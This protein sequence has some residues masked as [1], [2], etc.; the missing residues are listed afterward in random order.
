MLLGGIGINLGTF[1]LF[2]GVFAGG[3]GAG[4]LQR[5]YGLDGP[6]MD[7][8]VGFVGMG[9]VSVLVAVGAFATW[10]FA[11]GL[12]SLYWSTFAGLVRFFFLWPVFTIVAGVGGPSATC[13]VKSSTPDRA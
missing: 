11:S 9:V 7:A 12:V 8:R 6:P 13:S 10:Y 5:S 4:E 1:A 3:L 2:V